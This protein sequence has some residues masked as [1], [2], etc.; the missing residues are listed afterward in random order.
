MTND[1]QQQRIQ[2]LNRAI[3]DEIAASI[4]LTFTPEKEETADTFAPIDILDYIY[5]VLR[6]SVLMMR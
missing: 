2:N 5:A 6:I 4:A 3:V 1:G